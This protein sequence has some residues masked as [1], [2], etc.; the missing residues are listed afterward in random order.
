MPVPTIGL[1]LREHG[2]ARQVKRK[3]QPAV[4]QSASSITFRL[5]AS[6]RGFD[7]NREGGRTEALPSLSLPSVFDKSEGAGLWFNSNHHSHHVL[8]PVRAGT[9][10]GPRRGLG[11]VREPDP[12]D[13]SGAPPHR[14]ALGL[15]RPILRLHVGL[16]DPQDLIEDLDRGFR[17]LLATDR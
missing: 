17:A 5:P 4:T 8:A 2:A 6:S 1:V 10:F 14:D 3:A 7:A 12:V 13:E 9:L 15:R 11:R 16:E